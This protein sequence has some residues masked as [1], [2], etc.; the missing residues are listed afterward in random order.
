MLILTTERWARKRGV[1]VEEN[2]TAINCKLDLR[3][4]DHPAHTPLM[5]VCS[6]S[7]TT[8][9]ASPFYTWLP[10]RGESF[11]TTATSVEY[12]KVWGHHEMKGLKNSPDQCWSSLH[13]KVQLGPLVAEHKHYM[14]LIGISGRGVQNAPAG[15][16]ARNL[17]KTD[18][19][20]SDFITLQS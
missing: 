16:A 3:P 17:K 19:I 1:S 8:Q 20:W 13:F 5:V 18:L 10:L 4:L 6:T 9:T 7:Q 14:S 2:R 12:V 15:I 11:I